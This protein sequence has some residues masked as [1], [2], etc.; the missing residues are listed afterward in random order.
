MVGPV[1]LYKVSGKNC[2]LRLIIWLWEILAK[3]PRFFLLLF[4]EAIQRAK[5]KVTGQFMIITARLAISQ[6]WKNPEA[7][8][9]DIWYE[10]LWKNVSNGKIDI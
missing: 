5:N 4:S 9:L 3:V 2:L 1:R 7:P 8:L 10:K 6:H